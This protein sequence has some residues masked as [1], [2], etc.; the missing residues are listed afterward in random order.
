MNVSDIKIYD[1]PLSEDEL[2]SILS[3][4]IR[5]NKKDA[6]SVELFFKVS[7][8]TFG[9]YAIL[10]SNRLRADCILLISTEELFFDLFNFWLSTPYIVCKVEPFFSIVQK[11]LMSCLSCNHDEDTLVK[12]NIFQ[13]C[14]SNFPHD[15][16]QKVFDFLT[17][18]QYIESVLNNLFSLLQKSNIV[19]KEVL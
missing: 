4:Q 17:S 19:N 15:F 12:R 2:T 16:L 3:F 6:T 5:Q 13:L 7:D 8:F 10:I 11:F 14:L 9:K 1:K 18:S